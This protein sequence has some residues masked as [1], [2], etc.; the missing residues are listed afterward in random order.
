[1]RPYLDTPPLEQLR[2]SGRPEAP[3]I[4]R[5][6]SGDNMEE[7][8]GGGMGVASRSSGELVMKRAVVTPQH[9]RPSSAASLLPPHRTADLGAIAADLG[10]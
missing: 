5:M 10:R 1:M 8:G 7:A 4:K 3:A 9:E 6:L 2:P